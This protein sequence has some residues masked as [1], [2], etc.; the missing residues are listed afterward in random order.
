MYVLLS[1]YLPFYGKNEKEVFDKIKQGKLTFEQKEF[2]VISEPAKDLIKKLLTVDKRLR[3]N[4]AQAL[5]HS[6]FKEIEGNSDKF[7]KAVDP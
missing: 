7:Q 4:C 5:K 3:Y 2:E 1:G 6:W